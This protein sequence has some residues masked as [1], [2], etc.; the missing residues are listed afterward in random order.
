MTLELS[1]AAHVRNTTVPEGARGHRA[2]RRVVS[3]LL[4]RSSSARDGGQAS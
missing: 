3:T 1:L 2:R 4:F